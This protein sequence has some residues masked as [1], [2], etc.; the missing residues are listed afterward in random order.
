MYRRRERMERNEFRMRKKKKEP[1][2]DLI[3][4][5][6]NVF[7]EDLVGVIEF[8]SEEELKKSE[9]VVSRCDF[10]KSSGDGLRKLRKRDDGIVY[11]YT[12]Y[13]KKRRNSNRDC[14]CEEENESHQ[15]QNEGENLN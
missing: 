9:K 7:I 15:Y 2:N 12:K 13:R 10:I 6:F 1:Q 14:S 11:I 8:F 5:E 4:N 3:V